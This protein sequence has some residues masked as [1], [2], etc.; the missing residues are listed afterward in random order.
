MDTKASNIQLLKAKEVCRTFRI[1]RTTLW[2]M[3]KS[4]EFPRPIKTGRNSIA[5]RSDELAQWIESRERA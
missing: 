1:G 2:S 4:G 5:W 3:C